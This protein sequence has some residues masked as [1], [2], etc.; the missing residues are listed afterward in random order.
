[1]VKP[2]I[3]MSQLIAY[4]SQDNLEHYLHF[5][6]CEDEQAPIVLMFPA[7]GIKST[8]YFKMAE[9]FNELGLHLVCADLRG[10]G[11][12]HKKPS[13]INNFSY[14]EMLE[15][16][17]PAAVA[18]IKELH[19]NN[20]LFL[21]GH[22]LG[23]QLSTCYT[24]LHPEAVDGIILVASGSVFYRSFRKKWRTLIGTQFLWLISFFLGYLPGKQLGFGGT[25]ARG[26]LRDWA[27]NARTG[28]YRFKQDTKR[29]PLDGKLSQLKKPILAISFDGDKFAPHGAMQYLLDKCHLA[30]KTH[31]KTSALE[32]KADKL[33]HFNWVSMMDRLAPKISNWVSQQLTS[34][35]KS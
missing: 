34:L 5:F 35:D 22:S 17:W 11:P 32:L 10:N 4:N 8:Y 2:A 14:Y 1:M 28:R 29:L 19:P 33:D 21:M 18:K 13:W 20:P 16:D 15:L 3:H 27:Y 26:V 7:M 6:A 30:K 25:E 9:H 31:I 23:G 24:A 12:S